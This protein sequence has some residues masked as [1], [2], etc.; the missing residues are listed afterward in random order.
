MRNLCNNGL[1]TEKKLICRI[2]A[3]SKLISETSNATS[4]TRWVRLQ[5]L[6]ARTTNFHH[7]FSVNHF[8]NLLVLFANLFNHSLQ[9]RSVAL[10]DLEDFIQLVVDQQHCIDN[11]TNQLHMHGHNND[12]CIYKVLT[13]KLTVSLFNH[14]LVA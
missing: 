5:R 2:I 8:A 6:G 3:R 9:F 12:N 4:L 1:E 7:T 10:T 11:F 14:L 13:R